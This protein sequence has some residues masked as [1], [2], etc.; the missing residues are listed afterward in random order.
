MANNVLP[1]RLGEFVRAYVIG[2]REKLSV[3]ASFATIVIERVFDGCT[4]VLFMAVA[5][6][7]SPFHLDPQTMA[8]VRTMSAAGILLYI[9]VIVFLIF[10]KMKINLVMS[11]VNFMFGWS[12]RLKPL[13]AK[14]SGIFCH[15]LAVPGQRKPC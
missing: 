7:F 2:R 15:W 13:P 14:H 12:A 6:L 5:L 11:L 1:L 3:S 10:V 4:V 9:A 8:W